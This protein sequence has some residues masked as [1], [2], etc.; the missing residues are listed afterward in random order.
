[1][2][3]D[4]EFE[5]KV[6]RTRRRRTVSLEVKEGF[7]QIIVPQ[8]LSNKEIESIIVKKTKWIRNKLIV[9]KSKPSYKSM[10]FVSGESFSYLGKNY[11]LNVVNAKK[12]YVEIKEDRIFVY[13]RMKSRSVRSLLEDWYKQQG[14][15]LLEKKT[16]KYQKIMGV[17]TGSVFVRTYFK[18]WGSCSSKGDITF[19]WRIIMAPHSI[20]DY[21]VVHELCHLLYHNHSP[22]YW[23]T[24][25]SFYPDYKEKMH[26]LREH[27]RSLAW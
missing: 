22:I 2:K 3:F 15:K 9:Q 1:M 6:K 14:L 10:E 11:P 21:V 27:S 13:K 18:R 8:E 16:K 24:V 19:N 25:K 7:V 4:T 23:R 12:S 17:K 20:I 5:V 26:W